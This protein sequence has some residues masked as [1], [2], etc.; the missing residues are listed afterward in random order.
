[1][2]EDIYDKLVDHYKSG[3]YGL[4]LQALE[5]EAIET[6]KEALKQFFTPDEAKLALELKFTPETLAD[7][8][9]KT[10]KD[11]NKI[12][13]LLKTMAEKACVM[14]GDVQGQKTYQ[15]FEWVSMMEN[16]IRR[17]DKAD[18]FVEKM[19]IWWED[20]KLRDDGF[21][22]KPSPMRALPVAV[23][24]EK[25]GGILPYESV[26]QVI[27]KQDYIAVAECYCRKPKRLIGEEG[28]D[29]PLE[30]CLVFG[31]MAR[32]LV[33]YGYAKKLSQEKTLSLI[34]DCEDLGLVH[35]SDNIKDITWL[36]NCCGCCC[37]SLSSHVK[38][39]RTGT[40][41]SDFIVSFDPEKCAEA[42]ICGTCVDRCQLK[43]ITLEK[44]GVLPIIDY[45]KCIGC[46]SCNYKCPG[47]ALPLKRRDPSTVP[48]D[49]V[50]ELYEKIIHH[51]TEQLSAQP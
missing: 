42:G 48:S 20:V 12:Y 19:V 8:C 1:M 13:P 4:M 9:K 33:N 5:P 43:A 46:G 41:S 22:I 49:S 15:F 29:H 16:F 50:N 7:L 38:L 31:P 28:C 44:E 27:K 32:Y 14:E 25:I 17:T 23:E 30:V 37:I 26:T 10:G 6:F 45:E 36:C 40:T 51:I 18:P 21:E 34:K 47:D 35:M 2:K 39:G 24:I 11:E 3:L